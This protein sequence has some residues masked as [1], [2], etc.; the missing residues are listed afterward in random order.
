MLE[1]CI[2]GLNVAKKLR[3]DHP[4]MQVVV[5][6]GYLASFEHCVHSFS[7]F[8]FLPKPFAF[9]DLLQAIHKVLAP[10]T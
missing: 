10:T 2:D 8:Q 1:N 7:S 4:Q 6:S 5:I 9:A 3:A